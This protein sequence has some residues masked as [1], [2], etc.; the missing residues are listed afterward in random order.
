MVVATMER[1][2]V[3]VVATMEWWWYDDGGGDDGILSWQR[4][5]VSRRPPFFDHFNLVVAKSLLTCV[6]PCCCCCAGV[7]NVAMELMT[8]PFKIIT[9]FTGQIPC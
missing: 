6:C 8:L 9:W 7:A 2:W 5:F 4:Q 3:V 1:C